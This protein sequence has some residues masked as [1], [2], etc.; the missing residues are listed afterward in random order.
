VAAH[1]EVVLSASDSDT[2]ARQIRPH[3][4][5]DVIVIDGPGETRSP[6]CREALRHL[7]PGGFVVLDN[8]DLWPAAA[9]ILRESGLIQVDFTGFAPLGPHAHTTSVFFERGY[10]FSPCGARQ[11]VKSVAQP[12]EPWP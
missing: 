1:C 4:T 7:A 6:C 3:G 5:F 2:Y 10:R 12:V 9:A 8:S 11:P